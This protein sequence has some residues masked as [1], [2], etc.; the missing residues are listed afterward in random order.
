MSVTPE[1]APETIICYVT[2]GTTTSAG[3]GPGVAEL[4]ADEALG[5]IHEGLAIRGGQPPPNMGGTFGPVRP[6]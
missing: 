1:S 6:A 4:P 2:N 5:L 3:N